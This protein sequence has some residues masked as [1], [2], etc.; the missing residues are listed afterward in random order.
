MSHAF[1]EILVER[2]RKKA[3]IS[4]WRDERLTEWRWSKVEEK[5][6]ENR[7]GLCWSKRKK[8]KVPRKFYLIYLGLI[9]RVFNWKCTGVGDNNS[10]R[11]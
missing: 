10:V 2:K 8:E 4:Y 3:L 9:T 11:Y 7:N 6:D 1:V 5:R